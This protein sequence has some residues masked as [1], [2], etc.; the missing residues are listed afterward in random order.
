MASGKVAMHVAGVTMASSLGVP[1]EIIRSTHH[2][3]QGVN[4]RGRFSRRHF[5]VSRDHRL[6]A[7]ALKVV[8]AHCAT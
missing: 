1:D 7:D 4:E 2:H 8:Q 6:V 5:V 3:S